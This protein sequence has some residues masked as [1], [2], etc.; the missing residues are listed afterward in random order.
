MINKYCRRCFVHSSAPRSNQLRITINGS[1]ASHLE[2]LCCPEC[3]LYIPKCLRK[4]GI[5]R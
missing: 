1:Y 3:S 4:H 2:V 5:L